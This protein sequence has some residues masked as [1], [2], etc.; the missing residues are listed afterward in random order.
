MATNLSTAVLP[1]SEDI[2][3]VSSAEVITFD[4]SRVSLIRCK[5]D[6]ASGGTIT[7]G[8]GDAVSVAGQTWDSIWIAPRTPMTSGV[9]TVTVTP[10][11]TCDVE[12]RL[13]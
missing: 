1:H 7:L 6:H 2:T 8:A 3:G 4:P 13:Y 9:T 11:A 10:G 12:L 5:I